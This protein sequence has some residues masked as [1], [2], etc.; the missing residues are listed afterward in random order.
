AGAQITH[1]SRLTLAQFQ[2]HFYQPFGIRAGY[3]RVRADLQVER[4][5][6]LLAQQ[7][8]HRLTALAA[9]QQ[10]EKAYDFRLRY[11]FLRPGKEI[12]ARSEERRVGKEGRARG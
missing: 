1:L 10:R 7:I 6:A 12:A 11:I 4:P 8:G 3:Q 2:G 9:R 5:E